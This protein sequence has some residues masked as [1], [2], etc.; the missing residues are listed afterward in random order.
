MNGSKKKV[1]AWSSIAAGLAGIILVFK[2]WGTII[3][4]VT[5]PVAA[6]VEKKISVRL[7]DQDKDISRNEEAMLALARKHDQDMTRMME[8]F[9]TTVRD[10]RQS[11]A[12]MD[13]EQQELLM[14]VL[15]RM[16]GTR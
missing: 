16:G 10:L 2:T 9:D 1:L 5:P 8:K 15:R 7:E 11:L 3:E 14:E 13:S 6:A 4:H 12:K